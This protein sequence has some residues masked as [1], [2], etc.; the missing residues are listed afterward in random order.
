M[1]V[2]ASFSTFRD[3]QDFSWLFAFYGYGPTLSA[4]CILGQFQETNAFVSVQ[5]CLAHNIFPRKRPL[6]IHKD[7]KLGNQLKAAILG[8]FFFWGG[9]GGGG[10]GGGAGNERV[11]DEISWFQARFIRALLIFT[12]ISP[13]FN[14]LSACP[15]MPPLVLFSM[16]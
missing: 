12:T 9:G 14:W 4:K 5:Y 15:P 1:Q 16:L 8:I 7:H 2:C 11:P 10:G 13:R 6:V 3:F